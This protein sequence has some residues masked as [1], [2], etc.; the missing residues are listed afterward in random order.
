MGLLQA[1]SKDA[2]AKVARVR[3]D[4]ELAA[5]RAQQLL[6]E[7]EA[8]TGTLLSIKELLMNQSQVYHCRYLAAFSLLASQRNSRSVFLHFARHCIAH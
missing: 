5:R 4:A 1:I 2:L 7:L 8:R 3:A 6:P